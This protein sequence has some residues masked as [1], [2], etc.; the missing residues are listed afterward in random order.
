MGY[1]DNTPLTG[2]TGGGLPAEIWKETMIG[3]HEG[4]PVRRLPMPDQGVIASA[5]PE[6]QAPDRAPQGNFAERV[7]FGI[8]NDIFGR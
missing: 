5:E 6:R 1:D 3:V 2:V 7:I 4:L 8:I